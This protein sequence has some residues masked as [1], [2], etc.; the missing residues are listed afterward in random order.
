M[1]TENLAQESPFKGQTGLRRIWN[2]FGYS[3]SGLHAAYRNEDA[4]RQESLLAAALIPIALFLPVPGIDK[5]LM[6]DPKHVR[7]NVL[8]A[9]LA[10]HRLQATKDLDP[11]QWRQ[12]RAHLIT[13]NA[14]SQDD[15]MVLSLWHDSYRMQR[16]A[17]DET[18]R[19]ALRRAF[20]LIPELPELR[21]RYAL[22]LAE[23]QRF[24]EAQRLAAFLANDPHSGSRG[25]ALVGQIKALQSG[26]PALPGI[27]IKLDPGKPKP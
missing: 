4:F 13:A 12:A 18:A 21:A 7:S 2:A 1:N 27:E 17:P 14:V 9:W 10:M 24:D 16:R 5:A 3:L 8:K 19:G 6:I 26:N 15:P 23:Q 22:D 20:E 25:R 11:V